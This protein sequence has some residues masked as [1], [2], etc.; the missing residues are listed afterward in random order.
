MYPGNKNFLG[1]SALVYS[2]DKKIQGRREEY[3]CWLWLIRLNIIWSDPVYGL[4]D[5][6]TDRVD[7]S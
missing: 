3:C 2:R 7:P 5:L 1:K 4:I 6:S